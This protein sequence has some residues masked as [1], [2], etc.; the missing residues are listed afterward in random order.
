VLVLKLHGRCALAV[1]SPEQL[2]AEPL[3]QAAQTKPMLLAPQKGNPTTRLL[4][5][6]PT[7]AETSACPMSRGRYI[8]P[9]RSFRRMKNRGRHR[10]AF[11]GWRL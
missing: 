5:P 1:I 3:R 2:F 9:A 7:R 6:L 11:S 10:N 4:S 8:V